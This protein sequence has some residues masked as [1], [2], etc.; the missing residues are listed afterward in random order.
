M[1]TLAGNT[2]EIT[3]RAADARA[4]DVA[5]RMMGAEGAAGAW[6][7]S[8]L[9]ARVGFARVSMRLVPAMLNGFGTAHGGMIFALADS[10]FAYACNSRNQRSVAQAASIAF[11]D[12]GRSGELLVAE[13]R[14][15]GL[16]GRSGTYSVTVFGEDDRVVAT[17]QGLSRAIGGTVLQDDYNG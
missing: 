10:A 3:N 17:M 15:L 7:L 6:G 4:R 5:E 12:A 8:V 1:T 14:E 16:K 13:A 9:D 11:L 2:S